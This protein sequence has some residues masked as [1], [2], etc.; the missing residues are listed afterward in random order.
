MFVK[1]LSTNCS[2]K[3]DCNFVS[4][5]LSILILLKYC[6]DPIIKRLMD[7]IQSNGCWL[8]KAAFFDCKSCEENEFPGSG[9]VYVPG[10]GV[11]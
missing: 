7:A 2:K 4:N 10:K 11:A 8:N 6:T 1:Q 9:G 3:V 5:I